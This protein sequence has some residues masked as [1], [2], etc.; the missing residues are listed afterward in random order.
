MALGTVN[1]CPVNFIPVNGRLVVVDEFVPGTL[2]P[3]RR[4][5]PFVEPTMPRQPEPEEI[6]AEIGVKAE[7]VDTDEFALLSLLFGRIR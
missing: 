4:R 3:A 2:F 1:G 5:R 6:M 7:P